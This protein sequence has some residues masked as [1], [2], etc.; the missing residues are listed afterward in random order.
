M[1][2]TTGVEKLP[3]KRDNH[4]DHQGW[5]VAAC[6][7]TY[8]I[9]SIAVYWPVSPLSTSR[10]PTFAFGNFGLGD[11][12][13]MS[14]SLAWTAHALTH[15]LNPFYTNFLDFP[16]GAPITNGAPLLGLLM[17]PITLSA[18]PVAAFNLLLRL[19]FASSASSMFL[20]LRSWCRWPVAFV[21]GLLFAYG[22]YMVTQGVTHLQLIFLPIPPLIV[23]CLYDLLFTRLHRPGRMGVLLGGLAGAQALIEQELLSLLGVVLAIGLLGIAVQSRKNLRQ[24]FDHLARATVPAVIVFV[25]MTSFLLWSL[26]FG[27]G[28]IV[29]TVLPISTLQLY[30]TDLLGPIVPTFNQLLMPS[31]LAAT[32]AHFVAGNPTEN[33]TYLGIP[34][35]C[36]LGYFGFRFKRQPIILFS[37]L[38]ALGAFI[39]SLGSRLSIYGHLTPFALPETILAHIPLFDNVVP[40]RFSFVVFLFAII[41][42]TVGADRLLAIIAARRIIRM[43]DTLANVISITSL[44]ACVALLLPQVPFTTMKPDWPLNINSALRIIPTGS[45]VLTYP[46][47]TFYNTEAMSWQA[48]DEMRFRLIGGYVIVQGGANYG[49]PFQHLLQHPFIQEFLSNAEAGRPREYPAPSN[50]TSL[51]KALCRFVSDYNV[52]ALIFRDV[53]THPTMVKQLFTADFGT[54]SQSASNG[55][56]LVWITNSRKCVA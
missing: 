23:W 46:L 12:V 5:I 48:A 25:V 45:V 27:P 41:A 21:G 7:L 34:A 16:G 37:T 29:G 14:W 51:R 19:A 39:L 31:S 52:G 30:R 50:R 11:S 13:G 3:A 43:R 10:L 33:S 40:V 56:I 4:Q 38:L 35:M 24:R 22:P 53:G 36:L 26:L 47:T 9:T 54:P 44:V 32:A 17:S 1:A 8:A 28:H 42:L 15:G 18:G 20:V 6:L 49:L 55:S 2:M